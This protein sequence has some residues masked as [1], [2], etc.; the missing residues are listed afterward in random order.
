MVIFEPR[1]RFRA[2]GFNPSTSSPWNRIEPPA[3]PLR[4]KRPMAVMK[5]WLLPEPLSPTT[6]RH[7]PAATQRLTPR[8]AWTRPSWVAKSTV[9]SAM[10]RMGGSAVRR[11]LL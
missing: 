6:P 1:S 5:V 8:T 11:K 4:A 3:R 7:S 2:A 9:R 10:D